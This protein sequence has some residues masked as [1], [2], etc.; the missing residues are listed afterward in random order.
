MI[1]KTLN[2]YWNEHFDV[3]VVLF[4]DASL[5]L[6]YMTNSQR[7]EE[8]VRYHSSDIRSTQVKATRSGPFGCR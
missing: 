8:F 4:L 6:F 5:F 7:G 2:P 1:E 3:S